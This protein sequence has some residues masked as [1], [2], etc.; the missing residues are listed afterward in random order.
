MPIPHQP[1]TAFSLPHNLSELASL[2]LRGIFTASTETYT[3]AGTRH[4]HGDIKAQRLKPRGQH[5]GK[6]SSHAHP[7]LFQLTCAPTNQVESKESRGTLHLT[8]GAVTGLQGLFRVPE[9]PSPSHPSTRAEPWDC[10]HLMV[11]KVYS[12]PG[13]KEHF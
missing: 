4:R 9:P 11:E 2:S 6:E 1:K 12:L 5:Y 3:I 8:T 10:S 7:D 13:R